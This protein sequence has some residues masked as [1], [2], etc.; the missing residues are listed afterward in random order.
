M[1]SKTW[2]IVIAV[3]RGRVRSAA[4]RRRRSWWSPT[5]ER[6]LKALL[7]R[8]V[9][10]LCLHYADLYD[11]R[12]DRRSP[13]PVRPAAAC[14]RRDVADPRRRLLLVPAAGRRP[15]R[16]PAVAASSS[17]A[18]VVG[19]RL[20]FEWSTAQVGAARAAA[21]GRHQPG[22]GRA[23]ARAVRAPPGA[24]RRDRRLRRSGS[25]AGRRAGDQP[26][27]HRH[28]RRHPGDRAQPRRRSRRRQPGRRARQAADGQAAR[29]ASCSGV[30]FDHLASVYEEY[31]G[32][33]AVEN[34]RPSWLIFS[35]GF[36]QDAA[37]DGRQARCSTHR[38]R[39]RPAPGAADRCWSC[40]LRQARRRRARCSITRS[41]SA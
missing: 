17:I 21:A 11:L 25:G 38:R 16:V 8:R 35:D 29:D 40:A 14:A 24:R 30:Q 13:R 9:C 23:G 20:A 41:G 19:W 3:D 34:L 36:P 15:R 27:R 26:R 6:L 33:I 18:L 2:L 5:A 31:T 7:D 37:A 12:A 32:K 22:G 4:A 1:F 28:H 39:R 10:Q